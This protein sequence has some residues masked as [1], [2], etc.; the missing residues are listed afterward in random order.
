MTTDQRTRLA[1]RL[2][3]AAQRLRA[4]TDGKDGEMNLLIKDIEAVEADLRDPTPPS[5]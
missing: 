5:A 2:Y 3:S 4:R 1:D